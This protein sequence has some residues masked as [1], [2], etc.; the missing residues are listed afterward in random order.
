[1]GRDDTLRDQI[2]LDRRLGAESNIPKKSQLR[3]KTQRFNEVLTRHV[4]E[5]RLSLALR[6]LI[7]S[8][9]NLLAAKTGT[10]R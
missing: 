7:F 4:K 6:T 8:P 2:E 3:K 9:Q 5:V 10:I 1:M